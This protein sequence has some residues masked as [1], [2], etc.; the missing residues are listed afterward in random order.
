MFY[1]ENPACRISREVYFRADFC[2]DSTPETVEPLLLRGGSKNFEKGGNK[3]AKPLTERRRPPP[4]NFKKLDAIFCNL[5]YIL[6]SEW[7]HSK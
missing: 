6:G 5:A 3:G 7:R 4:E 2:N 1:R